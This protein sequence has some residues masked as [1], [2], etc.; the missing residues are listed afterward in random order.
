MRII[1]PHI[2]MYA[3][4]TDD[5]EAM[6]KVGYIAVIEPSFWSGTDRSCAGSYYDYFRHLLEFENSRAR[7]YG[8]YHYSFLGVNAKE[9]RHRDIAFEVIDNMEKYLFHPN[10]L[11][12]GEIGL[13]LI[14]P[15]EEEVFSRQ[16]ELAEKHKLLVIIHSPHTN[17]RVGIERLIEILKKVGA[18]CKRYIMDHNTE[19]TIEITLAQP[20][21]LAGITLYPTKVNAERAA[22]MIKKYGQERIVLNSSAD[23]GKSYPLNLYEAAKEFPQFGLK[24]E[25]IQKVIYENAFRFFS[26]SPKFRLED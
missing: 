11:G 17:K 5:Y 25:I 26:Q 21:L 20:D 4:T 22:D 15:T 13:D 9:S 12:V 6:K 7:K 23:W 18:D 16:V 10:C 19:E 1:E 2:H 8:L 14:T 3:R 24:D